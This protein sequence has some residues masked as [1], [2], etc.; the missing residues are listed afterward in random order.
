MSEIDKQNDRQ[1]FKMVPWMQGLLTEHRKEKKYCE[2]GHGLI[3][4]SDSLT[5]KGEYIVHEKCT[6]CNHE[7]TTRYAPEWTARTTARIRRDRS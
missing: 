2:L 1:A 3:V 4:D 6:T 7:F 5:G